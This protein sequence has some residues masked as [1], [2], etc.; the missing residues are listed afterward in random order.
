MGTYR[1]L[2]DEAKVVEVDAVLENLDG[3]LTSLGDWTNCHTHHRYHTNEEIRI[4]GRVPL[5]SSN[6]TPYAFWTSHLTEFQIQGTPLEIDTSVM[7][8]PPKAKRAPWVKATYS[9]ILSNTNK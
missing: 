3:S 9:D 4:V 6:L 7:L 5:P 2:F 1:V 8:H